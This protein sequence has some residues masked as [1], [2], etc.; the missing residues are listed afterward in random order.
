MSGGLPGSSLAE[1]ALGVAL[2][3]LVATIALR[4]A[5]HIFLSI[6]APLIGLGLCV[7]AGVAGWQ[8]WQAR[9]GGW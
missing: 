2:L 4:A 8:L 6:L 7:V 3:L 1:R 5:V 9:R